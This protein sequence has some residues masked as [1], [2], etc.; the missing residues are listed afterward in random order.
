MIKYKIQRKAMSVET[1]PDAEPMTAM[2]ISISLLFLVTQVPAIVVGMVKR[3]IEDG[4][5]S[6]EFLHNFFIIDGITKLLKW[7]NH[8]LNFFCYCIAGKRFRQELVAMVKSIFCIHKIDTL[9]Q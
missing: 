9:Y 7:A 8:A 3:K 1:S 5:R 2:L 6:E 4:S